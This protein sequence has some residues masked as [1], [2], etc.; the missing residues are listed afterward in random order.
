[1]ST[2]GTLVYDG[3]CAFCTRTA[4]WV[5]R[6]LPPADRVVAGQQLDIAEIGLSEHDVSSAAW[7]ITA[8]GRHHRGS[9]AIAQALIRM[10]GILRLVGLAL[11]VPPLSWL[12]IPVY[13]LVARYR[14]RLPGGTAS[15]RTDL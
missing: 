3:D 2:E 11:S 15:C 10:G 14:H 1:M 12:A 9:A 13:A 4:N 7:W 5:S 8:D 6:R